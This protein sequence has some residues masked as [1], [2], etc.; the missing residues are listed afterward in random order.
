M[1]WPV[2]EPV[3]VPSAN[4]IFTVANTSGYVALTWLVAGTPP[5]TPKNWS[6]FN[7]CV[8][9]LYAGSVSALNGG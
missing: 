7:V 5:T 8:G 3:L 6:E 1:I 2:P 4:E 9:K